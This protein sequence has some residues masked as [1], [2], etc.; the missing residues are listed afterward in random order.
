MGTVFSLTLRDVL[1]PGRLLV[2]LLVIVGICIT[3]FV[4]KRFTDGDAAIL[5]GQYSGTL[6][7]RFVALAAAVFSGMVLSQEIEQKTIVYLLT[8]ATPRWQLLLGRSLAAWVGAALVSV[9]AIVAGS[10]SLMGVS[11][12]GHA[13]MWRDAL[14]VVIGAAAYT[15]LFVVVSLLVN[16]AMI[17]CLLFAFGWETFVPNMPGDL[18]ILSV[19]PYLKV[20]QIHPEPPAEASVIGFLAGQ[21]NERVIPMGAAAFALAFIVIAGMGFG[22]AWFSQREYVPREDGD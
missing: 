22:M 4:W 3:G 12:L 9:V 21:M 11:A 20:F 1:R 17:W 8:R 2:W 16:R 10:V 15:S 7:M 14:L 18:T 13:P 5:L 19:Q 6:L